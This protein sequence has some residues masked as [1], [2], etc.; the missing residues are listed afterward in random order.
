M[1]RSV[2]NRL[3]DIVQSAELAAEHAGERDAAALA[4]ALDFRD[5]ALY[6][7]AIIGE[8]VSHFPPEVLTLA[9]EIPWVRIRAMRNHIIHGYWQVDFRIVAETVANDLAPLKLAARR[10]MGL[11]G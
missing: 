6:Q 10:L 8:A 4:H 3:A 11:I 1:S 9:P 7:I 5:A 2:R